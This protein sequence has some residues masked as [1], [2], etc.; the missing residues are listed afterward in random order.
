MEGTRHEKIALI[1]VAYVI[2]FTSAFIAF[3][4]ND[5]TAE[6]KGIDTNN[7][8]AFINQ[9]ANVRHT[10]LSVGLGEEGLFAITEDKERI[11]SADKHSSDT[12]VS[13]RTSG[14]FHAMIDA[15]VSRDGEY[16]YFCEQLMAE[17]FSCDPYV[18]SL[19]QDTLFPVTFEGEHIKPLILSHD[20]TWTEDNALVLN[21]AASLD[22]SEP[23]KL[24]NTIAVNQ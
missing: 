1:V 14:F 15:E 9:S 21:S 2:G 23:W 13:E 3:G 5:Y 20:S 11:L 16:V 22:S 8:Q 17:D 7:A 18:Y 10:S 24:G 6:K 4:I 12:T 19:D